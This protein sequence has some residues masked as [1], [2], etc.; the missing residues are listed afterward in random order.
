MGREVQICSTPGNYEIDSL[1]DGS[2]IA[3]PL[4]LQ[5]S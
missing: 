3:L 1:G 5:S 2:V 4:L